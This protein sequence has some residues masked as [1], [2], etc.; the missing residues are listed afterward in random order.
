MLLSTMAFGHRPVLIWVGDVSP[1]LLQHVCPGLHCC[2]RWMPVGTQV[3]LEPGVPGEAWGGLRGRGHAG[4][5]QTGSPLL[6]TLIT[7]LLPCALKLGQQG[8]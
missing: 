3:S 7:A 4:L 6:D 1:R 2:C 5:C 8:Q